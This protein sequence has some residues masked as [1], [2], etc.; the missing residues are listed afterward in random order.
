MDTVTL[1]ILKGRLEQI[2]DEMDATLFRSAFNPIIAEAHDASHGIY[3]GQTG[4][5]LIQ[6]KSGLP[7][8]V[9][10]MAFAVKAVIEKVSSGDR[11]KEGDVYIFNDPYDGG[12]HLSDFRLVKPIFRNGSVFCYIASVGH[13]HDVGGNV[14]GNYNPEA[15]ESFQEGILIPPVKL[16]KEGEINQDIVNILSAN[17]RLPNSLYGDCLLYTSPSPRD[18]G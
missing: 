15:T 9:G 13:W 11:L 3:D 5:T 16:F 4:E 12:T 6:G 10:V 8:F 18:R 17:S 14:P 1:A 7:I 2:A